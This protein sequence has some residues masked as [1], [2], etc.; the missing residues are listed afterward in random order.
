MAYYMS[1]KG[2]CYHRV[3][4]KSTRI[5]KRAMDNANRKRGEGPPG[6]RSELMIGGGEVAEYDPSLSFKLYKN[7]G[8][9]VVVD[10]VY[11]QRYVVPK[12]TVKADTQILLVSGSKIHIVDTNGVSG[13][14]DAVLHEVTSLVTKYMDKIFVLPPALS[15]NKLTSNITMVVFRHQHGCVTFNTEKIE[16]DIAALNEKIAAKCPGMKLK[17][18]NRYDLGSNSVVSS[19]TDIDMLILCLY[20]Q[21]KCIS[22]VM[23]KLQPRHPDVLEILSYTHVD[24]RKKRYNR[25]LRAGALL[26]ASVLVCGGTHKFKKIQSIAENPISAHLLLSMFDC[27][28]TS[29]DGDYDGYMRFYPEAS[30]FD[31]YRDNKR[32]FLIVTVNI[33]KNIGKAAAMI[34]KMLDE[35]G[36]IC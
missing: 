16:Q 18:G 25:L 11:N 36:I 12:S 21:K 10:L 20:H 22:S 23:L 13:A 9:V 34:D 2:Y 5:S 32:A 26:V 35:G 3:N 33:R 6:L 29:V 30:V 1:D 17:F 8:D 28:V 4:G 24:Y 19:Y 14:S 7:K 15:R 31:F 27:K